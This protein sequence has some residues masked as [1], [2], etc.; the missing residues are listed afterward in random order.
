MYPRCHGIQ[1]PAT[2]TAAKVC[3]GFIQKMRHFGEPYPFALKGDQVKDPQWGYIKALSYPL[4][5]YLRRAGMLY[6]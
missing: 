4:A 3:A 1:G 5:W 6:T 2:R